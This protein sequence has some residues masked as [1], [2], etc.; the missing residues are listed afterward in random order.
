VKLVPEEVKEWAQ[1][2]EFMAGE[3]E[4]IDKML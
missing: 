3:L 2:R 1:R 4:E